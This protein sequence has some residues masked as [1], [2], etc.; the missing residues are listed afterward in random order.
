MGKSSINGLFSMAML[1]LVYQRDFSP[2]PW[3][4]LLL[5]ELA[6]LEVRLG[7]GETEGQAGKPRTIWAPLHIYDIYIYIHNIIYIY[8]YILQYI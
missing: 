2:G 5:G 4:R 8:M 3:L 1:V 6:G 7:A